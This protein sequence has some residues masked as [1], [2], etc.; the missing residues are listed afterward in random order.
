[1]DEK[2]N[3]IGNVKQEIKEVQRLDQNQEKEEIYFSNGG[4]WATVKCCFQDS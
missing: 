4:G 2:Q 3:I 1:M